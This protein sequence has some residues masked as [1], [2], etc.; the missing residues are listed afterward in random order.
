MCY[1]RASEDGPLCVAVGWRHVMG[2][3]TELLSP[4]LVV[5]P[6]ALGLMV[7]ILS[8]LRFSSCSG[9]SAPPC[10]ATAQSNPVLFLPVYLAALSCRTKEQQLVTA[11]P[12]AIVFASARE[13]KHNKSRA[14]TTLTLV[15]AVMRLDRGKR[16]RCICAISPATLARTVERKSQARTNWQQ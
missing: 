1:P 11:C 2:L 13:K 3:L 16:L 5:V 14:R 6:Y 15:K 10:R 7:L 8:A 12:F 9:F 4:A